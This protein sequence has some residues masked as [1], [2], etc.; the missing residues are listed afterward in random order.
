MATG[1]LI[2]SAKCTSTNRSPG[3]VPEARTSIEPLRPAANTARMLS[4]MASTS[5]WSVRSHWIM[6]VV[7][8]VDGMVLAGSRWVCTTQ[9]SLNSAYSSGSSIR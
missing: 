6:A 5:M 1:S 8:T 2:S 9:A 3:T 4:A 7:L